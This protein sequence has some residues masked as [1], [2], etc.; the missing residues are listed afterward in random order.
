[1]KQKNNIQS[2]TYYN[3]NKVRNPLLMNMI[4]QK[5]D[6]EFEKYT[7]GAFIQIGRRNY[8]DYIKIAGKDEFK[9]FIK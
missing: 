6:S 5:K 9:R 8:V 4:E 3:P 2:N 7:Q 1:M